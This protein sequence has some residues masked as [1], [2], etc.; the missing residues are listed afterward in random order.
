MSSPSDTQQDY[1]EAILNLSHDAGGVRV[2]DIAHEL[3]VSAPSV[4]EVI[5]RMKEAGLVEQPRRG[6]IN[7]TEEGREQAEFVLK[8]HKTLRRF[9]AEVLRVQADIAEEDACKVEH[10]ISKDTFD[11]L[12]DFLE[13]IDTDTLEE[14]NT[15]PITMMRRGE[16]GIIARITG[17][18]RRLE[19]L[20]AMGIANGQNVRVLQNAA[21]SPVMMQ[22]GSSCIAVGRGLATCLHVKIAS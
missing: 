13:H 7:L 8:R 19:R 17:G 3:N 14:D 10:A 15:I 6:L 1:L 4:V 9:F 16:E 11:R 20:A 22:A 2:I 18:H 12:C 5:T 21:G